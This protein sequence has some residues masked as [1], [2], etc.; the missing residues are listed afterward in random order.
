MYA[1]LHRIR[2]QGWPYWL[3]TDILD[4]VPTDHIPYVWRWTDKQTI[5]LYYA[6]NNVPWIAGQNIFFDDFGN[7]VPIVQPYEYEL[8]HSQSLLGVVTDGYEYMD[9]IQFASRNELTVR[10]APYPPMNEIVPRSVSTDFLVYDKTLSRNE[11]KLASVVHG[12]SSIGSVEHVVY[13]EY[14]QERY[15]ELLAH[16]KTVVYLADNDRYPVA[17]LEALSSG[18]NVIGAYRCCGPAIDMPHYPFSPTR[19][20]YCPDDICRVARELPQMSLDDKSENAALANEWIAKFPERFIGC[21]KSL[22][23]NLGD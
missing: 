19:Y 12:L 15:H 3:E 9:L 8:L 5:A 10:Q 6:R 23:D 16:T 1:L 11:S 17:M 2:E 4:M 21:L 20:P 7:S 22:T 14:N 13:G 18:C